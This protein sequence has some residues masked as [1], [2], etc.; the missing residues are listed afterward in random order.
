[1][2]INILCSTF[3]NRIKITEAGMTKINLNRPKKI[4]KNYTDRKLV[5]K[6]HYPFH[7]TT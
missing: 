1:M 2:N 5:E 3:K 7:G 6:S 4:D